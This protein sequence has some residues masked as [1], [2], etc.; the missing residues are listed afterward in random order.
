[1]RTVAPFVAGAGQM[2]F[3]RFQV[4]NILGAAL[5]V[6]ACCVAGYFFGN[7]PF[8]REHFSMVVLFIIAASMVPVV[9]SA[10]QM[11]RE[12]RSAAKASTDAGAPVNPQGAQPVMEHKSEPAPERTAA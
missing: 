1:V 3:A 2:N 8:V 6:V 10:V 12:A 7:I 4:Y 9:I 5:W 11:R